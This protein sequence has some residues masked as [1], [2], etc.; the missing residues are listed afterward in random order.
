M[1]KDFGSCHQ[2]EPRRAVSVERVKR[3]PISTLNCRPH[4][5]LTFLS[6]MIATSIATNQI[7]YIQLEFKN[8]S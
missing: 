3:S 5:A 8:V 1:D 2:W 7:F 6:V 4:L